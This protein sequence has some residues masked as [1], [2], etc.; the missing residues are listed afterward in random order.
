VADSQKM[1]SRFLFPKMLQG[2]VAILEVHLGAQGDR[3]PA[4]AIEKLA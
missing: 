2:M 1:G 4:K 3:Q